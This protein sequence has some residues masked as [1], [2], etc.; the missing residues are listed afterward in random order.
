MILATHGIVGSQIVQ[1]DADWL[2]YYNRVITAGGLL[3]TTEQ[4]ATQKLVKDLKDYGIWTKMKAIYPMVGASAA[5]CAQNL[6]S[7]SFTGTFTS[8]WTFASSGITPNGTSDF[9][10]T[11]L[12]ASTNLTTN[13]VH[14]SF[15]SN[16]NQSKTGF[17]VDIGANNSPS[18]LPT[19]NYLQLAVR[20]STG[21]VFE[22]NRYTS[23]I[24]VSFSTSDS[25]GLTLGSR[26][27]NTSNKIYKNGTLQATATSDN[28]SV[29]PN[30]NIYIG[31]TNQ[32]NT[33]GNFSNITCA[34][35]SIGDGL[36]DT[37]AGNFY[38][39]VQAFQTTLSRNV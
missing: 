5:A 30:L 25:R 6:K 23:G 31:A 24:A 36:T 3:S 39:L 1:V 33:A 32:A 14:L 13:N 34:F 28:L 10:N 21:A 27:T 38:T 18:S 2:A 9:M 16:I 4:T 17:P 7:L 37:E 11:G 22:A 15:Y 35:A 19:D 8:N 20:R 12:N 29:N 26:T